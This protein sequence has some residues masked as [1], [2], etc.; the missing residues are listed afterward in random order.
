MRF[1]VEIDGIAD[2]LEGAQRTGEL[3]ISQGRESWPTLSQGSSTS[4]ALRRL[5][6]AMIIGVR[7]TDV[8]CGEGAAR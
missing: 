6:D 5:D 8:S 4:Q 1:G 3:D 7:G 2:D